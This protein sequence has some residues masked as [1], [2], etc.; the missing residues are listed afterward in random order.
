MLAARLFIT[1]AILALVLVCEGCTNFLASRGAVQD[2][3]TIVAYNADS[4][5]LYGQMYSY[6][7]QKNIPTG[8]MRQVSKG[9]LLWLFFI[10]VYCSPHLDIEVEFDNAANHVHVTPGCAQAIYSIHACAWIHP[11][12]SFTALARTEH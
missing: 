2:S 10:V 12:S 3:S 7:A 6:P 11:A 8:T 4:S 5:Y 1:I 9:K